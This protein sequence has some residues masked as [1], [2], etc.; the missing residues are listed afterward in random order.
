MTSL[1]VF[2]IAKQ[3]RRV[4]H[5]R[6]G[7][8]HHQRKLDEKEK[9]GPLTDREQNVRAF[10]RSGIAQCA[11]LLRAAQ[12]YKAANNIGGKPFKDARN[13]QHRRNEAFLKAL[14]GLHHAAEAQDAG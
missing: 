7:L 13:P 5:R 6:N 8:I 9:H 10:C 12:Y 4:N 2:R 11:S 14:V 3:V 1:N